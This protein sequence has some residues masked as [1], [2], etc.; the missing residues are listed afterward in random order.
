[1]REN[2]KSTQER[3]Y[4]NRSAYAFDVSMNDIVSVEIAQAIGDVR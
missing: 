2:D 3:L 1:M 4:E